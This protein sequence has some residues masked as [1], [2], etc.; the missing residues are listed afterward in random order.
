VFAWRFHHIAGHIMSGWRFE[1]L[2]RCFSIEN[3]ND[4]NPLVGPMK[5]LYPVF[6]MLI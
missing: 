4:T 3:A 2:C 1:K 5:K 6:D